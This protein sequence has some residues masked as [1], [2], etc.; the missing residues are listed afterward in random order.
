MLVALRSFEGSHRP[1]PGWNGQ[2]PNLRWS[3]FSL[4]SN[5]SCWLL[6]TPP[7]ANGVFA[8]RAI[9]YLGHGIIC[10]VGLR[11]SHLADAPAFCSEDRYT[12]GK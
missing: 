6:E 5:S 12:P 8:I 2:P 11:L 7:F 10:Y 3:N 9:R 1:R 4:L